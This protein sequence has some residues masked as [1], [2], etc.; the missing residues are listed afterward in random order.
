MLLQFGKRCHILDLPSDVFP[1]DIGVNFL[2][3]ESG[4]FILNQEDQMISTNTL[5]VTGSLGLETLH[6][7]IQK[8][9]KGFQVVKSE[10][11]PANQTYA[12]VSTFKLSPVRDIA[13]IGSQMSS[14][15]S[16]QVTH[17]FLICIHI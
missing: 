10:M 14:C 16:Q 7:D 6:P 5:I 12:D 17:S 15:C 9:C 1:M 11:V 4:N 13:A 2:E 3:T 8:L